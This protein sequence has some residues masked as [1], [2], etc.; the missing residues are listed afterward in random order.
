[1]HQVPRRAVISAAGVFLL[2][3]V[4][5]TW[6]LA[7][8]MNHLSR[9]NDDEW[10]NIWAVSW[11][12]HQLPREPFN[13]LA[14]NIYYPES[15]ALAYTE[16]LIVPGLIGAPLRWLGASPL[17]T[18]NALLFVG[19]I[20]TALTMFGL[21]V[22]WTGDYWAG[23]LAGALLA[24]STALLTRLPHLQILHLYWLPLAVWVLDRFLI[25][26]KR[27]DA[28]WLG[29]CVSG[30]ALTSGYL[31][32]FVAVALGAAFVARR[33]DWWG[34]QAVPVFLRL[35]AAALMTLIILLVV[36]G[37]YQGFRRP[38]Q[39]A[40]TFENYLASAATVHH[41]TWSGDY[42]ENA[43][44]ALFPGVTM[45]AL[46]TFALGS[47]RIAPRGVRRMLVGIAAIGLILSFGESTPV[48]GWAYK[49]VPPLQGLRATSR[50]GI[51]VIF[52]LSGLAGLG[53]AVL[54]QQ[55][56]VRWRTL[57]GSG[58]LLV[59]TIESIHA[60]IPYRRLDYRTPVHEFLAT[61]DEPGAVVELPI[62]TGGSIHRN[63]WYLLASTMHWR[64]LVN[65]FGGFVPAD[66]IERA[67]IAGSFPSIMSLARLKE[68]G[69]EFALVHLNRYRHPVNARRSVN[70]AEQL[71]FIELL[72]QGGTCGR[73]Q[74]PVRLYRINE[75][76]PTRVA[77]LLDRL[78]WSDFRFS[79]PNSVSGYLREARGLNGTFALEGPSEL[80]VYMENT[81]AESRLVLQI[82]QAMAGE[83]FDAE[84]GEG[85][86]EIALMPNGD[87]GLRSVE[88]P[89]G[90]A[91]VILALKSR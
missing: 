59:A 2:L 72:G 33:Q 78:K 32:V 53:L 90:R 39:R 46:A 87:A 49:L 62:Y 63:A 58:L 37:P 79:R 4:V 85:L 81:S 77:S 64:S 83:F 26:R 51:L 9:W 17:F 38:G 29:V 10:L 82:R 27:L 13:L 45:L 74:G 56:Y 34:R 15:E 66:Y 24:F 25:G 70:R 35:G 48:Y 71:G 61:L 42:Y 89:A 19:L 1:M 18:Y 23:L 40:A 76:I 73:C 28:F 30:A 68:L 21:V 14:A 3:A 91:R 47:R 6:P 44:S 84:T 43:T 65:G 5:H 88:V 16:P 69:V 22:R 50:F 86:S 60:P 20:L 8:G 11:V 75:L 55:R 54:R 12:A 31:V 57:A 41:S 36:L 67:R 7:T 52:A 80:V